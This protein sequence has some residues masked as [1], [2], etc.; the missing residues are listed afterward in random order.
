M[1]VGV[2]DV[3]KKRRLEWKK[4]VRVMSLEKIHASSS[5]ELI[6]FELTEPLEFNDFV[7]LCPH[8][9]FDSELSTLLCVIHCTFSPTPPPIP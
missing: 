6:F 2:L 7:R 4:V 1:A 9:A 8:E 3:K 5:I